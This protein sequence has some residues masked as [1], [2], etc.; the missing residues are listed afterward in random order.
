MSAPAILG[1]LLDFRR[2]DQIATGD[3]TVHRLDARAKVLVTLVFILCVMSCG[4]YEVARLLPFFAF[5]I[6]VVASAGIPASVVWRQSLLVLPVALL[7][8]L[9]NPIFDRAALLQVDGLA[10][11]GG[12]VSMLSIVLRSLLA[13]A[14]SVVLVAVTGFPAICGALER[15]G[16]PRPL[17]VQ[18]LFLYRYLGVLGAEALRMNSAY[19][20]RSNGHALTLR[21]F[22][23][24]TGRLLLRTWERAERVYLAMCARGF[25]GEFTSG[26]PTRFGAAEW[27]YL[28]GWCAL[29]ILLRT[30][31]LVA[32]LGAAVLG[33]L[34]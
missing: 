5:P 26:R 18:L 23:S 24:L 27:L 3:S 1:S 9:P 20:L 32:R 30:Q 14:A 16:M 10:I 25:T 22:G 4:R 17:A 31:D 15:L 21:H 2:L 29:F 6:V 7:V 12:W 28:G 33:G 13:A 11:S 19:E 34:R 8:G